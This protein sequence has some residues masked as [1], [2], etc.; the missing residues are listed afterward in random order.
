LSKDRLLPGKGK[1]LEVGILA[2][3]EEDKISKPFAEKLR[4]IGVKL[5]PI[6]ERFLW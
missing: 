3:F 1:I 5:R 4:L 6:S 2:L